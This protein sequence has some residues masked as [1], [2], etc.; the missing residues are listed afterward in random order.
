[1]PLLVCIP[2]IAA[3]IHSAPQVISIVVIRADRLAADCLAAPVPPAL[4]AADNIWAKLDS[5]RQL[6]VANAD[7]E[8][9]AAA[10]SS[11]APAAEGG[12]AACSPEAW[13]DLRRAWLPFSTGWKRLW[14]EAVAA[15]PD[16]SDE[17][18][19]RQQLRCAKP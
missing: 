6:P 12:A 19:F 3:C 5:G 18:D 15:P 9:G 16:V 1:M 2:F 13:A 7:D 4:T 8:P 17:D 10:A 14:W 11:S